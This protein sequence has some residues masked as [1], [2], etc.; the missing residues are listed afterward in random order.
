[1]T[2]YDYDAWLHFRAVVAHAVAPRRSWIFRRI[3]RSGKITWYGE[4]RLPVVCGPTDL[5]HFSL[6]RWDGE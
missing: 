5:W 6:L 4:M 3:D 2:P 1:M